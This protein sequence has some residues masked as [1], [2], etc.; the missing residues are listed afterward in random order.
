MCGGRVRNAVR[1]KKSAISRG[2]CFLA[3]NERMNPSFFLCTNLQAANDFPSMRS[4][5]DRFAELARLEAGADSRSRERVDLELGGPGLKR[6]DT[7]T[8]AHAAP[9]KSKEAN[10]IFFLVAPGQSGVAGPRL[11]WGSVRQGLACGGRHWQAGA[12]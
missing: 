12:H 11:Q 2:V 4:E 6:E 5:K 8:D 9:P 7:L 1:E 10:V 3:R